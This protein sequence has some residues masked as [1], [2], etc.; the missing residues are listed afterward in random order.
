M[1]RTLPYA[2]KKKGEPA[3]EQ[4]VVAGLEKIVA[5]NDR[6]GEYAVY[7]KKLKTAASAFLPPKAKEAAKEA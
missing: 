5:A 3:T 1:P 4:T 2:P 7:L 6:L